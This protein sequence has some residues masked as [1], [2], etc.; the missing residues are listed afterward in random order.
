MFLQEALTGPKDGMY[1]DMKQGHISTQ[2]FAKKTSSLLTTTFC[3]V[4]FFMLPQHA[5]VGL[6]TWVRVTSVDGVDP[7]VYD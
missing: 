3:W 4:Y 1:A 7:G 2:F 5:G 6:S